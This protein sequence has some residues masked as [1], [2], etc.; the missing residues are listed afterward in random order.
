MIPTKPATAQWTAEQWKAIW[1]S[2][3]DI[4]VSAAAGSGKTAVLIER[5]IQK[6]LAPEERRIDVDQLLVVTFTNASAAEMRSRMAEALEKAIANDPENTF[7]RRQLSLLNK[8]Q[9]STLHS[10]CL[11]I[12]RQY[13]YLIDLDPGF[14]I[15]SQDEVALLR[16]DVLAEVL[17]QSYRED[18]A[19]DFTKDDMYLLV[20]SFTADRNDQDIEV[21][22]EKLYEMSRVQPDPFKWLD[23][24]PTEYEI[25]EHYTVDDLDYVQD[26]KQSIA[27]SLMQACENLEATKKF[28]TDS[29]GLEAYGEMATIEAFAAEQLLQFIQK[30]TWEDVYNYI[31]TMEWRDLRKG[32]RPKNPDK[33]IKD[34]AMAKRKEAKEIIDGIKS[35]FFAR[36]PHYLIQ[37]I[38]NMRPIIETLVKL[39][40]L[41]SVAFKAAKLERGLVDFSDLEHFALEILTLR[42]EQGGL[43][44]S[45]V[46]MQFQERF[47]EVLVD[48]YQDVN[49]LQETILQLV[50]SGD[51]ATGNMF[52]VGDVKQ[53]IYAFRL[54][55][56]RLFLNK[57]KKFE[58]N[59]THNGMKIDLNANFRSRQ[60]VLAST[61]YVF[62]QI[63]D[64]TVGEIDYDEQ[65]ALK[66]SARYNE[67]N[68]PVEL[69]VLD[70][71][72]TE[73]PS[74]EADDSQDEKEEETLKRVQKEA[75][76]MI[77]QIR[78]MVDSGM[79]VFNPKDHSTRPVRYSDIVILMRSMS[80][81]PQLSEEFKAAG[82]PL[83][84][85]SSKGYFDALEV[86]IMLNTLKVIDNPYQDIPLASVLRAPFIGLTENELAEIR[87]AKQNATFYEAL[88]SYMDNET[89]TLSIDT[90]SKLK[91]FVSHLEQWRDFARRGSLADLIWQIYLQTNYFEMVGAMTNGKQRQANLRALHDRALSYEKTSFRGLFRFLRFID[92]MKSRGDDLGIAKSIGEGDNVV[93][94]VTI[95][96][97]KGLEF[98]VVFVA[99]MAHRF[100]TKDFHGKYIFDQDFGLAV[101]AIDPIERII[102]TSLPFLALKE[103]KMAKMKAEEM[104]ILY[105]AM[106][107]AKERLILVGSVKNWEKKK[108]QWDLMQNIAANEILPSYLRASSSNYLEWVGHAVARHNDYLT[109]ASTD[110]DTTETALTTSL[111]HVKV[112]PAERFTT[113]VEQGEVVE[114][115]EQRPVNKELLEQLTKRFTASYPFANAVTKKSKTSVTEIKRIV[116]LQQEEQDY[117][118]SVRNTKAIMKRPSFMQ[119]K[120]LSS[121]EKGTAVHT[122]MQLVP[123]QGLTTEQ[124]VANF[125]ATLVEKELLKQSEADVIESER[126]LQFFHSAIGQRFTN[127][128]KVLREVPFTLSRKDAD[129]DK[130]IVQG[131]IDCMFQETDGDWVLLDYKTDQIR[132]PFDTEPALTEELTKRYKVQLEIYTEAIE[133][134]KHVKV[135]EKVLYLYAIGESIIIA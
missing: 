48:E 116:S 89:G 24:L 35:K 88:K 85:E 86:M 31:H 59:P 102:A 52:M 3:Q 122:V 121:A 62:E 8:A 63:M 93:R 46:A 2:G 120:E 42:D 45:D 133:N 123:Q 126:I 21:L 134:I 111:W 28:C 113:P 100:N 92:R 107:R 80:W 16:D 103:K 131:V 32:P 17:E 69:V 19:T 26:L 41:Y 39:T 5:L 64:E 49:M 84:A 13:A 119:E 66:F 124:E 96:S 14:R 87:L 7:L 104:R 68:I 117:N 29:F 9:I 12:C 50:K 77:Q 55:E 30:D 91:K 98:P 125:I 44:P 110:T 99:D 53:S 54:A 109:I 118:P 83:Y 73:A 25:P 82:I 74:G 97:S 18:N 23:R 108:A 22:I 105:V 130:Q 51:E 129:G 47:S 132:K 27:Y 106:T 6:I 115:M 78:K 112:V 135:K 61:N 65:A 70:E 128:Q 20:D 40:K 76:Y 71:K 33:E 60:E 4:L 34:L 10:F 57:Y 81:A 101:K 36:K 127:A 79:E 1:A 94:L 75:R 67:K 38:R 114:E 72:T 56:P 11:A 37:E 90:E 95:H 58:E 43:Q 15:A